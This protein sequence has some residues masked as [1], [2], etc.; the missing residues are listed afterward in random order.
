[1]TTYNHSV[2]ATEIIGDAL[3]LVGAKDED[4][5]ATG[6]ALT[7]GLR[8]LE[9]M[10][11][12]WQQQGFHLWKRQ[13]VVV[14]L[15][16]SQQSY[17]LGPSSSDA[18]WC[19]S[20]DFVYTN[21]N[22]A[23]ASGAT[24]LTVDSTSSMAVSD[25][26][27]IELT[28]GTRQWT[29][30]LSIPSSTSLTIATALTGAASDNGTVFTYTNRPQRPLEVIHARRAVYNGS[31]VPVSVEALNEY[32][33][34]PN[35]SSSGTVTFV[36]YK[37][38]LTSGVLYVWQTSNSVKNVV[39]LTVQAP[40]ADLDSGSGTPDFPIEW[41]EALTFNLAVRL[42]PTYRQ[43]DQAR[44]MELKMDA[45]QMLDDALSFDADVGP[46]RIQPAYRP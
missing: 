27:G 43:L 23:H 8:S 24:T 18:E 30:I 19:D 1:M 2:N 33:D 17:S 9:N 25:R 13:E 40:L 45:R 35:K 31:D 20:D 11:K 15:N 38:T 37:P 36:A 29:T 4:E 3:L 46:I 26:I 12:A 44:R 14:F 42:E 34:T 21:L 7:N 39:K 10:I 28:A 16:Q 6:A 32:F 41:A 5:A 22:G